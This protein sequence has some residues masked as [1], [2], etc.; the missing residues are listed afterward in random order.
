MK[1]I[2]IYDNDYNPITTLHEGEFNDARHLKRFHQI[3]DCRFTVRLD[4]EKIN[5]ESTKLFN[6]VEIIE[7][8]SVRFIG[9]ITRK[10]ISLNTATIMC[11]ELTYILR[12]RLVDN[13]FTL[14][15]TTENA[16][17][18][19][20]TYINNVEDTGIR[21]GDMSNAVGEVNV[22][23]NRKNAFDILREI[24]EGTGNEFRLNEDGDIDVAENIG[25]D[26]TD[27]VVLRYERDLPNA[28][29]LISFDIEESGE[30]L[31]TKVY[32]KSKE[33]TGD[34]EDVSLVEDFGLLERFKNYRT[35]EDQDTLDNFIKKD[36][37]GK[38]HSPSVELIPEID[39][40]FDIGD[41]IRFILKNEIVDLDETF[42][43][44]QKVVQYRQGGQVSINLKVDD[45]PNYLAEKLADKERRISLLE[46]EI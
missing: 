13:E 32:G 30:D 25:D 43:V 8:G 46:Q 16:L 42:K 24:V 23:Y 34:Y 2:K 4:N 6:R 28:S 36:I 22:T 26:K 38:L 39:T 12:K 35:I 29:T 40:D 20:L 18:G 7:D 1:N 14:N 5:N 3:G 11:R 10:N 17:N 45:L 27:S 15:D 19:L 9:L 41:D 37:I 33:L 44:T 21:A 31:T